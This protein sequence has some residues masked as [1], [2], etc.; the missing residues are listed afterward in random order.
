[1][2]E[3]LNFVFTS[4]WTWAGSVILVSAAGGAIVAAVR[5]VRSA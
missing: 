2:I 3:V 4:F 5:A 1:M